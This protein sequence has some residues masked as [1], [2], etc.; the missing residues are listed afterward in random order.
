MAEGL[1]DLRKGESEHKSRGGTEI[2]AVKH[3]EQRDTTNSFKVVLKPPSAKASES[4]GADCG[5]KKEEKLS[6]NGIARGHTKEGTLR[7]SS[8]S[9]EIPWASI[10]K[11]KNER[12]KRERQKG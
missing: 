9:L 1:P 11:T 10:T 8:H 5:Q 2:T 3:A 4:F 12:E 7:I 6:G